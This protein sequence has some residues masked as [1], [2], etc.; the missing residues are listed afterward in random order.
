MKRN[1]DLARAADAE[2][3]VVDNGKLPSVEFAWDYLNNQLA[4]QIWNSA[5]QL[6]KTPYL[7]IAFAELISLEGQPD[8]KLLLDMLEQL[9]KHGI[10]II[11]GVPTEATGDQTCMLRKVMS[12]IGTLRNTFYGETWDVKA[13]EQSKNVAYTNINLGLHMD[14]LS[15]ENPPRFQ[16]LHC[17]RNRVEGGAS[18]F[19]DSFAVAQNFAQRYR[20]Q[21]KLLAKSKI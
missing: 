18:Y 10:V 16:A 12:H 3:L 9:Q 11:E 15:F 8:H 17:L 1:K 7:K 5:A 13:V 2:V 6:A 19:V 20:D 21:A 4:R 14:L